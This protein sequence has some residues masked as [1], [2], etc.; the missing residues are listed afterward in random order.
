MLKTKTSPLEEIK[1]TPMNVIQVQINENIRML[2]KLKDRWAREKEEEDIIKSL[3]TH[4]T[5]TTIQVF[6]DLNTFSTHHTPSPPNG[7]INGD[8][9]TSTIDQ[10]TPMNLETPKK[11]IL[12]DITTTLINGSELDFDSCTLPEVINFLQRMAKD[13]HTSTLNIA[14][15][16]HITNAL[17]KSRE[18]KLRLEDGWDPM[19]KIKLN[20]FSCFDLCDV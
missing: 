3:P 12:D 4:T 18:E 1:T 15:M 7:P 6:E 13:P 14:F 19:V 10:E 16:E 5:I 11:M 17:I 20:N 2:D 9:N 8:A